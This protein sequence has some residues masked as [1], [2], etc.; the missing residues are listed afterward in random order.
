MP[1]MDGH[2]STR[3]IRKLQKPSSNAYIVALTAN[4]T[5]EDVKNSF[6]SG[7][8]KFVPKPVNKNSIVKVINEYLDIRK[9]GQAKS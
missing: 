1:I 6:E 7:M 4:T 5:D 2:L 9:T 8:N 3:N